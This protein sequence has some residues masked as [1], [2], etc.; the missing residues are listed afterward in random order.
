MENE[1]VKP[2]IDITGRD[3]SIPIQPLDT[4]EW[5]DMQVDGEGALLGGRTC[6]KSD[7]EEIEMLG[8]HILKLSGEILRLRLTYGEE[9]WSCVYHTN[10]E[11]AEQRRAHEATRK[12][13]NSAQASG[14]SFQK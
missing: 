5:E 4:C 13:P 12:D 7:S 10:E 11:E 8:S 2:M 14:P 6:G 1:R 3:L 9:V